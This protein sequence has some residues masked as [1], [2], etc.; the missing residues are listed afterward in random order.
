MFLPFLCYMIC[1]RV[2]PVQVA[3]GVVTIRASTTLPVKVQGFPLSSSLV[4]EVE[5]LI[6][7]LLRVQFLPEDVLVPVH[8]VH[9]LVVE[10]V[11][12]LQEVELTTDALQFGILLHR[13]PKQLFAGRIGLKLGPEIVKASLTKK[14]DTAD[15]PYAVGVIA[16][17]KYGST[18]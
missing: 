9:H 17:Y 3:F 18:E 6:V 16:T 14:K 13:H 12:L 11:Q 4:L 5:K 15:I 10:L 1:T 7:D 2:C 8:T